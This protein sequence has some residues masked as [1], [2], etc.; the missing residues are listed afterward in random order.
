[1]NS[2]NPRLCGLT[3]LQALH[4]QVDVGL[5]DALLITTSKGSAVVPAED[6]HSAIMPVGEVRIYGDFLAFAEVQVSLQQIEINSGLVS[7]L[8]DND[9]FVTIQPATRIIQMAI[10]A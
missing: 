1:M 7:L 10:A 4:E 9:E 8:L 3:A 6:V 5:V 2:V